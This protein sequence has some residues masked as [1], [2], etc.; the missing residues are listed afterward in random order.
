MR[1]NDTVSTDTPHSLYG[2]HSGVFALLHD[3]RRAGEI[4]EL[5][6]GVGE[7]AAGEA[8]A[9]VGQALALHGRDDLLAV[10]DGVV[11]AGQRPSLRDGLLVGELPRVALVAVDDDLQVRDPL[12]PGRGEVDVGS[13]LLG[14]P[15]GLPEDR[16]ATAADAGDDEL[17]AVL[18]PPVEDEV[19][20][21]APARAGARRDA[22][23]DVR[24]LGPP[25]GAVAVELG[26]TRP[27][28]LG[29]EHDPSPSGM[30]TRY[31]NRLSGSGLRAMRKSSTTVTSL[32]ETRDDTPTSRAPSVAVGVTGVRDSS[33]G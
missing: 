28:V 21:R 17:G 10:G 12:G 2:C 5:G 11:A 3:D 9:E 13:G 31:G 14:G 4:A 27:H 18:P 22:L 15:G 7:R 30:R 32:S 8:G 1:T 23:D 19:D 6:Q 20:G 33:R 25:V 16:L 26:R 24:V 29:L